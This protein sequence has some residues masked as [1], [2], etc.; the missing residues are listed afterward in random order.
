[1]NTMSMIYPSHSAG[2]DM[3]ADTDSGKI[4]FVSSQDHNDTIPQTEWITVDSQAVV[5]LQSYR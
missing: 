5:D 1:M 2:I 3:L 4:T